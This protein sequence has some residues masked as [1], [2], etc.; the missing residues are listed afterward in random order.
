VDTEA[1]HDGLPFALNITLVLLAG[2]V[3]GCLNGFL[4][5]RLKI[6]A[7]IATL[8]TQF[9]G[10]GIA[11]TLWDHVRTL[12]KFSPDFIELG[13]G[14][15]IGLYYMTW[16]MLILLTVFTFFLKQTRTG[17]HFYFV[18]E[19]QEAS[20]LIGI[21]DSKDHFYFFCPVRFSCRPWWSFNDSAYSKS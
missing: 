16:I 12:T 18:G 10:F 15:I 6:N 20:L 13:E 8:G 14:K 17:R 7:L 11:M 9:I 4:V 3:L 19:N 2:L 5:S 21:N 1:D